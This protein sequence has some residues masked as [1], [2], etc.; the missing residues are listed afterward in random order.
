[1]SEIGSKKQA[2]SEILPELRK[3]LADI[4]LERLQWMWDIKK[5][6]IHKRIMTTRKWLLEDVG[7]D[8]DEAMTA[9]VKKIFVVTHARRQTAFPRE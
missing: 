2:F 7:F 4:Y 3:V 6:H 8:R 9:A 5:D 1:M